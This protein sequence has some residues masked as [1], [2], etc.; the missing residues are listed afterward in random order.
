MPSA[1]L[2]AVDRKLAR[3]DESRSAVVR[4]LLEAA[5]HEVAER[6]KAERYIAGYGEQPQTEE[7]SSWADVALLNCPADLPW[8]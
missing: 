4:R 6:E 8:E 5:L 2:E 1:L 3:G 7:E